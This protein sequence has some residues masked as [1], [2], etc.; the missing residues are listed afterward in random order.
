LT[1]LRAMSAS[2]KFMPADAIQLLAWPA[3]RCDRRRQ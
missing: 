1:S 2:V 3:T